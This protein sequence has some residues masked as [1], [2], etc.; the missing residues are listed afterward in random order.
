MSFWTE[1]I[2]VSEIAMG[3]LPIPTIDNT[4]GVNRMGSLFWTSNLQNAYP[5]NKG[6]SMVFTLSDQQRLDV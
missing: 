1:E 5:G 2:S 4:P 6:S 3:A